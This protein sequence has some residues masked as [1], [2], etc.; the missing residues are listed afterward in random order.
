MLAMW[1]RMSKRGIGIWGSGDPAGF[2]VVGQGSSGTRGKLSFHEHA[3]SGMGVSV[4][5]LENS[6]VLCLIVFEDRIAVTA[7]A[8][9]GELYG[10]TIVG[11][12][13]F[14]RTGDTY[15]WQG[16]GTA[17]TVSAA[18]PTTTDQEL[19]RA[20]ERILGLRSYETV[21]EDENPTTSS[22]TVEAEPKPAEGKRCVTCGYKRR[23]RRK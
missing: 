23:G 7:H 8:M 16:D 9:P 19:I 14:V 2:T 17:T 1:C 22:A 20:A 11:L 18:K 10:R 3:G 13:Q 6:P 12:G 21:D 15:V 4:S 5:V